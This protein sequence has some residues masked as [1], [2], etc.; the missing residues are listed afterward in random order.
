MWMS[1]DPDGVDGPVEVVKVTAH[2]TSSTSVTVARSQSVTSARSHAAGTKVVA[3][4]VKAVFN[5]I[6]DALD[7]LRSD[8]DTMFPAYGQGVFL[9]KSAVQ[10]V[11]AGNL[12]FI[13]WGVDT[14][15]A[16]NWHAAN[17]SLITLPF[18]GFYMTRLKIDLDA[19]AAS[20]YRY[21]TNSATP[22]SGGAEFSLTLGNPAANM[23]IIES[24]Q[25]MTH[26]LFFTT[27]DEF[28][29]E[30]LDASDGATT[31]IGT[32]TILQIVYLG[33]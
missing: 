25:G 20:A 13:T 22:G 28:R 32:N 29:V 16:D 18:T 30:I 27:G 2:S 11:S 3:G 14:W 17:A 24:G 7:V 23:A 1:L 31:D 9:G 15:D 10:S 12:A 6:E 33:R 19:G 26:L 4:L 5:E 8:V 21:R